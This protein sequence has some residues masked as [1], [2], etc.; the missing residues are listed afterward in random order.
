[1]HALLLLG[2]L[3]ITCE[4]KLGGKKVFLARV[5]PNSRLIAQAKLDSRD[6]WSRQSQCLVQS[7]TFSP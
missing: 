3:N 5:N 4:G 1:M 2:L 6:L 7:F